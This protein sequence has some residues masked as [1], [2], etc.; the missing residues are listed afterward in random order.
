MRSADATRR[1]FTIR[2]AWLPL[3]SA[4]LLAGCAGVP[5]PFMS[6]S[7]SAGESRAAAAAPAAAASAA[8]TPAVEAPVPADVQR[9]FDAARQAG[10][11]GRV[12]EAERG[13]LALTQAHPELGGPH[14]NLGLLRLKAG[15]AEEA[16]AALE[17]AVE[18]SPG[19]ASYW[20]ALG[21][22]QRQQGHFTE[23]RAAY[24]RAIEVDPSYADAHLNL[25]ILHDLYLADGTRALALYE[26][27]LA[28]APGGDATVGK[29][30]ADL[31]NR[32]PQPA[33]SAPTATAALRGA[34]QEKL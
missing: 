9:A 17:R 24:E 18:R 29:W 33:A 1:S 16:Q 31:K 13:F 7:S 34:V 23:A 28:L 32:K 30:I 11:A 8:S 20:N 25:G 6:A 10:R 22:A 12:Q 14:A 27:Y 5:L 4:M 3:L 19:Q 2:A 21:V 15:R 26:R